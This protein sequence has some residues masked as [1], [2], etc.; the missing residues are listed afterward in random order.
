MK[1]LVSGSAMGVKLLIFEAVAAGL[2]NA[3]EYQ[4]YNNEKHINKTRK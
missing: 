1:A 3:C 4:Y 2:F